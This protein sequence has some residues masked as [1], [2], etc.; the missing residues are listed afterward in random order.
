M[1]ESSPLQP[2]Q[3]MS[4]LVSSQVILESSRD[5][6]TAQTPI[7]LLAKEDLTR[8]SKNIN[9]TREMNKMLL[10]ILLDKVRI[11]LRYIKDSR[12]MKAYNI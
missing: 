3:E 2:N 10:I 5:L 9:L 8:L 4:E 11:I 1:V 7:F 6:T 12:Q